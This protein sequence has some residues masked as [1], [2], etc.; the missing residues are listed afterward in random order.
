MAALSTRTLVT[1]PVAN[2]YKNPAK[3]VEVV[4]QAIYGTEV[5]VLE[6]KAEWIRVRTP[7]AYQGWMWRGDVICSSA[8][9]PR[10]KF[11]SVSGLFANLYAQSS[12]SKQ[13]PLL[14][15]PYET[16]L[17]QVDSK[18]EQSDGRWLQVYLADGD[19]AWVEKAAVTAH[20]ETLNAKKIIE[21]A[22]RFIGLPYLWGGVSTYGFDCSGFVQMLGRRRGV[23]L[24][25]DARLQVHWNGFQEVEKPDWRPGDF[26]YFGRSLDGVTH[27][28]MY[29][30]GGMMIHAASPYIRI[31]AVDEVVQ[32]RGLVFGR[33]LK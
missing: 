4:S 23:N 5:E 21:H 14:T 30:G 20:S 16:K 7:D 25:R 33:R 31:Q 13:A 11:V 8:E 27:T 18:Q 32:T 28:G 17:E 12:I 29:I 1:R 9:R 22:K 15:V 26:L 24:P 10:G 3:D 6:E 19:T 2:L